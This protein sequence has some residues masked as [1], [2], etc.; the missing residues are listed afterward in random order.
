MNSNL[1]AMNPNQEMHSVFIKGVEEIIGP[2]AARDVFSQAMET[3]PGLPFLREV[4]HALAA[5]YGMQ[6]GLGVAQRTG[7]AAFQI[8]PARLGRRKR[9]HQFNLSPAALFSPSPRRVRK[10]GRLIRRIQ[11]GSN[12]RQ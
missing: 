9:N 7:R 4:Q 5:R 8:Q 1:N 6:S 3:E 12:Q 2:E 10:N 11:P